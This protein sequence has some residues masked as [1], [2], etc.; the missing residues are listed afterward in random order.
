MPAVSACIVYVPYYTSHTITTAKTTSSFRHLFS[1]HPIPIK[2]LA[3]LQPC[4]TVL[5][6]RPFCG[7]VVEEEEQFQVIS[8]N[9]N[10]SFHIAGY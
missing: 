2:S 10:E 6:T 5:K 8:T 7:S 1:I 3:F 9:Q 4:V